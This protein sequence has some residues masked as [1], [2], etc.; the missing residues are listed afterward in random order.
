MYVQRMARNPDKEE[1][2]DCAEVLVQD[3]NGSELYVVDG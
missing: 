3:I 2:R 1:F